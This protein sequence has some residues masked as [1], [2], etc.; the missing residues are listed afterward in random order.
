MAVSV[1]TVFPNREIESRL[2]AEA[3]K[4]GGMAVKFVS[5]GLD[6]VPDRIVLLPG[7]KIAFV[8]LFI[9]SRKPLPFRAKHCR[10]PNPGKMLPLFQF[11]RPC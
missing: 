2:R 6:G 7:R 5:P 11:R 1:I 9:Q 4:M 8:G 10:H 3:K